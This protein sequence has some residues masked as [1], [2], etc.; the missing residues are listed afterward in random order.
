MNMKNKAKQIIK[1]IVTVVVTAVLLIA[2]IFFSMEISSV[3]NTSES[4]FYQLVEKD[5]YTYLKINDIGA[6]GALI[7]I[8]D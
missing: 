4:N 3:N 2:A 8:E 7:K 5:G 6:G 1:D